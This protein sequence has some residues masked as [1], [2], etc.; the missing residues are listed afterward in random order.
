MEK[1]LTKQDIKNNLKN[2]KLTSSILKQTVLNKLEEYC[3][4]PQIG[5]Q[6]FLGNIPLIFDGYYSK[7]IK[8][9]LYKMLEKRKL[10][11]RLISHYGFFCSYTFDLYLLFYDPSIIETNILKEISSKQSPH[12]TSFRYIKWYRTQDDQW[13]TLHNYNLALSSF[14]YDVDKYHE[15]DPWRY[16]EYNVIIELK[17]R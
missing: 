3:N 6:L 7:D 11:A 1:I 13:S 2:E 16:W 15:S 5:L 12:D 4:N 10:Y 8:R 14:G 9:E 17:A